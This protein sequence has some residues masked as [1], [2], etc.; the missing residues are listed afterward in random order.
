[1]KTNL[2]KSVR[3]LAAAIIFGAMVFASN[4]SYAVTS[5][6]PTGGST[7]PMDR[8]TLPGR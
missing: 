2:T 4:I 7:P 1:M 6:P 3:I 5:D 8:P